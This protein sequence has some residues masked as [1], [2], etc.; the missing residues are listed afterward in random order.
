VRTVIWLFK[1]PTFYVVARPDIQSA[2]G[3]KGKVIGISSFG[4]DTDL[5]IKTF[6]A[7]A[8]LDPEKDLPRIV[9]GSTATRLRGSKACSVDATTLTPPFN[10]YAEQRGMRALAYVGDFLDFPQSGFTVSD[11]T[12]KTKRDPIKKL[13]RGT[14]HGLQFTL[15]NRTETARFFTNDDT[16]QNAVAEK[17]YASLLPAMS[18]NGLAM[19]RGLEVMVKTLG[20]AVGKK[21]ISRRNVWSTA[22]C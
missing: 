10:D 1:K 2:A 12:L 9:A 20:T 11:A 22:R 21:W 16:P 6:A 4:S 3:L 5:S 19:D 8:R 7:C 13:L 17:V 14:L 15:K 18:E